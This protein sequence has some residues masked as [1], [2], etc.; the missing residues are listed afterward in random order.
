MFSLFSV[1]NLPLPPLG[2]PAS[3]S[4]FVLSTRLA[5]PAGPPLPP[6]PP[7]GSEGA[8]EAQEA[9]PQRGWSPR[10][11]SRSRAQPQPRPLLNQNNENRLASLWPLWPFRLCSAATCRLPDSTFPLPSLQ[12]RHTLKTPWCPECT[13]S[14]PTLHSLL[15]TASP[16]HPLFAPP[17]WL[18]ESAC[19]IVDSEAGRVL[20]GVN[21][22]LTTITLY[23]FYCWPL[24]FFLHCL[25]VSLSIVSTLPRQTLRFTPPRAPFLLSNPPPTPLLTDNL[26]RRAMPTC[27]WNKMNFSEI[28]SRHSLEDKEVVWYKVWMDDITEEDCS[29]LRR[30]EE[31][32]LV[33]YLHDTFTFSFMKCPIFGFL[34]L[35]LSFSF[36]IFFSLET[37]LKVFPRQILT[38]TS[39]WL[40]DLKHKGAVW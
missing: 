3:T 4:S 7:Q 38:T 16:S 36:C 10:R 17:P 30:V 21:G 20:P 19:I 33:V 1:L 24:L 26:K 5:S 34:W 31:H 6:P 39:L 22:T 9:R 29:R 11:L 23:S 27:F 35:S 25:D 12:T 8:P 15:C 18:T 37:Q 28:H 2:R 32:A 13:R 14:S 40:G